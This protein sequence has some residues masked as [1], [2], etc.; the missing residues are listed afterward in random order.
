MLERLALAVMISLLCALQYHAGPEFPCAHTP[1]GESI[2]SR[3]Q[4]N[5]SCLSHLRCHRLQ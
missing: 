4:G 5:V 3:E 2:P 1:Q